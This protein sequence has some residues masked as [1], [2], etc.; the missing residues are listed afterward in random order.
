LELACSITQQ[1]SRVDT[2]HAPALCAG[3][4]DN[5][6]SSPK[7]GESLIWA[8]NVVLLSSSKVVE[9]GLGNRAGTALQYQR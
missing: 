8:Y 4:G 1:C 3:G 2:V 5:F 7:A 6:V 9:A